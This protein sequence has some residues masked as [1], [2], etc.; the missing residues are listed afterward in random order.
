MANEARRFPF[1]TPTRRSYTPGK[2]PQTMFEAQN[3]ATSVMRFSSKPVN[4]KLNFTFENIS[5]DDADRLIDHYISVNDDWDYAFFDARDPALA[6]MRNDLRQN[7]DGQPGGLRWRYMEPP[8]VTSVF[9]GI[10][11]VQCK[12]CA[13]LD[14]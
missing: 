1:L 5:D 2:Y 4:A 6:G 14:G 3:G 7:I 12:L 8:T 9:P 10:S 13:Y 11:T